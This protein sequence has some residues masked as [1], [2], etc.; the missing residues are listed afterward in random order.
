MIGGL[1]KIAAQ[2]G[3]W[4]ASTTATAGAAKWLS[5]R[6]KQTV[7][8]YAVRGAQNTRA[9]ATIVRNAMKMVTG[10]EST[11]AHAD[12]VN[13]MVDFAKANVR[14]SYK[15]NLMKLSKANRKNVR[16][17]RKAV[18]NE[19]LSLPMNYTMYRMDKHKA[20]TQQERD[21]T[22]SFRKYYIGT[23]MAVNISLSYAMERMSHG[24]MI[25][26]V[27]MGLGKKLGTA[28]MK[29]LLSPFYTKGG[30]STAAITAAGRVQQAVVD[31]M[32]RAS[33]AKLVALEGRSAV[34][35]V[36]VL[37]P[38]ALS[39]RIWSAYKNEVV[40]IAG[41]GK[42]QYMERIM[43]DHESLTETFQNMT[44]K[45]VSGGD[46]T[47]AEGAAYLRTMSS[48]ITEITRNRV[49]KFTEKVTTKNKFM[50]LWNNIAHQLNDPS[51]MLRPEK[52]VVNESWAKVLDNTSRI[53]TGRYILGGSENKAGLISGGTVIDFGALSLNRIRDA[54]I[55][56]AT[57]GNIGV[58]LHLFGMRD[59][60]R[61]RDSEHSLIGAATITKTE[62]LN[63]PM[64]YFDEQGTYDAKDIM[65]Q[66][67]GFQNYSKIAEKDR[68]AADDFLQSR[69]DI[70]KKVYGLAGGREVQEKAFMASARHGELM[71]Q[72]GDMIV[73]T[74]GGRT[75]IITMVKKDKMYQPVEVDVGGFNGKLLE[76]THF[77][78]EHGGTPAKLIRSHTGHELATY[79]NMAGEN[80]QVTHGPGKLGKIVDAISSEEQRGL[81]YKLKNTLD[82]GYSQDESIFS[83]IAS[84][85]RKHT[86]PRYPTTFFS[87]DFIGSKEWRENT[88]KTGRSKEDMVG[89]FR[90]QA[91]KTMMEYWTGFVRRAPGGTD[92]AIS[93][94]KELG[95]KN[96]VHGL[97][98]FGDFL[99]SGSTKV[100]DAKT[101]LDGIIAAIKTK[102]PGVGTD[103][104]DLT[105][106]FLFRDIQDLQEMR[107]MFTAPTGKTVLDVMGHISS[108]KRTS[109]GGRWVSPNKLDEYNALVLR[110]QS[111]I[112]QSGTLAVAD[113]DIMKGVMRDFGALPS[114]LTNSERSAWYAASHLS[115]EYHALASSVSD[116]TVSS[117]TNDAHG[118]IQSILDGI[119]NV[120]GSTYKDV[121]TYYKKRKRFA[122]WAMW[123]TDHRLK[124]EDTQNVKTGIYMIPKGTKHG[125]VSREEVTLGSGDQISLARGVMDASNISV[126]GMFHAFNRAASEMLGIGFDETNLSTPMQYFEKMLYQRV[127][128]FTAMYMGYSVLDRLADRYMDGTPF[129]EGL[130]TFGANILAGARVGAQGFLD[131]TGATGIAARMEDIMPGIITSPASGI[132]RGIG[133]I[134]FGMAA[135]M[136]MGG[137][138]GALTGGLI[139]S[140]VGVLAGGGPLGVFGMWDISKSRSETIQELL[141]EKEVAVRKGRWWELSSSPFE[142]TR[143]EYYRPHIYSMIRSRYKETPGFKDSMFTEMVGH[144]APDW[145][146]MKDYY[147]RPYPVTA[148]LF[149]NLPVFGSMFDLMASTTKLGRL[150]TL[151]GIPM[152]KGEQSPLWMQRMGQQSGLSPEDVADDYVDKTGF[153]AQTGGSTGSSPMG[154]MRSAGEDTGPPTQ[155]GSPS[156]YIAEPMKPS[157]FEFGLGSTVENV[158]EIVGIRGFMLGTAFQNMT[159]R[160]N[161]F[162][163][164][165]QLASPVDIPGIQ[166]EYWDYELGGLLGMSEIVRRYINPKRQNIDIYNPIRNTMPTWLPG[167]KYYIDFQHGDPFTQVPMGEARL[168]GAAYETLHD[169]N[170]TMPI[171]GDILGENA[172]NQAAFFLGIPNYTANRNQA[173]DIAKEVAISYRADAKRYGELLSE[174]RTV[175]NVN[176]DASAT[177]DAIISQR[178][179]GSSIPVKIVPKGFGGES[180]LN[181]YLVMAGVEQGMLLEVNPDS[182]GVSERM[183]KRDVKKFVNDVKRSS[184]ARVLAYNQITTLEEEGKSFNLAN[185]YSWFDRYKILA[186]VA[187]FSPEYKEARSIVKK[188]MDAGRLTPNQVGE[189]AQIEEQVETKKKA[190]EFSEYR[191]KDL[192]EGLTPYT[193]ARDRFVKDEYSDLEQKVG[194]IW[195]RITHI[196]NPLQTKFYHNMD[197]M[198]E[199]QRNA[200]YGK[201]LKMWQNPVEDWVKSYYLSAMGER[202]P[203]QA[204]VNW[205]TAGFMIGGGP[206]AA[207][208]AG[209][210]AA[211]SGVSDA[212]RGGNAYIPE[213]TL[214]TREVINQA[215]AVKYAKYMKLYQ[216]TGDETYLSQ[217]KRTLTGTSI[218]G[219]SLT[220]RKIGRSMG[221]PEK[222]Y[223]EDIINNI[224]RSNIDRATQILPAPAVASIYHTMGQTGYA[225]DIMQKFSREQKERY[226]PGLDSPI[227]D[228]N[229]PIEAPIISTMEQEGLN[230][231]D[232]GYGWYGQ[233]A[234]IQQLRSMGV[235]NGESLYNNFGSRVTVQSFERSLDKTNSLRKAL[236]QFGTNVQIINDGQ[237]RVVVELITR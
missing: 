215:D 14:S 154:M 123:D 133:P 6:V 224:T 199:Y 125:F 176:M 23:P 52:M 68:G 72:A 209:A 89:F 29:S 177:V 171:V 105:K 189:F 25:R 56:M 202:D 152:H 166:R 151:R 87:K 140:A 83:R 235:Y 144:L 226:I 30:S 172:E 98:G 135:G 167:Y 28:R 63:F 181:A 211:F 4:A 58:F 232:A 136:K 204:S 104:G 57:K 132:A 59:T 12:M 196:R 205:A 113:P 11:A 122:P 197:A 46:F 139:G 237:D 15:Q 160:R 27:T 38:V 142:G 192:G 194:S 223:A 36:G 191:F 37:G 137:P 16:F 67:S 70:Y 210:G 128:P 20:V 33:R 141:G 138:R 150:A 156:N 155:P 73:Q 66:M 49:A 84:I 80:I 170:L 153:Y 71:M 131:T 164:A 168:P 108:S 82:I 39:K 149:S 107:R 127:V 186:D 85:F 174:E 165:P 9:G 86:D 18:K 233:M 234:Q 143:V 75:K 229:V 47:E 117:M 95:R 64:A 183:V 200:I 214:K 88:I 7:K 62:P 54:S 118:R 42:S 102:G 129:G 2:M 77:T 76:F 169:V 26:N 93:I 48:K 228:K 114:P 1:L 236:S 218:Q 116:A 65:A 185:A 146:A 120:E 10:V 43:K 91:D 198:E 5:S 227:Y 219:D 206:L 34:S 74:P 90:E 225:Q 78:R 79:K 124:W 17:L 173:M 145:Y 188:Q 190:F 147:T 44:K 157:S 221:R 178:K 103:P 195:E 22:S 60:M 231:H 207:M 3:A 21:A 163:Y 216:E 32:Q 31:R 212:I 112:Y 121:T 119:S 222:D 115:R 180:N 92:E 111:G 187:N 179:K 99:L 130:T 51:A 134:G 126:M 97:E 203:V 8:N 148:G 208:A 61:A 81:W 94:F 110:L 182:G 175:Y 45:R 162:D 193:K 50:S 24:K 106:H 220:A 201:T 161:L 69:L 53:P 158:K 213:R 41:G 159:G 35:M 19:F 96:N 13:T 40:P 101:T 217:A 100:E 109:F 184:S 230:A 55:G